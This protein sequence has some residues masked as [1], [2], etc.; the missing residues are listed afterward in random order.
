MVKC[1]FALFVLLQIVSP[2]L[3]VDVYIHLL[4]HPRLLC[5][6]VCPVVVGW[7]VRPRPYSNDSHMLVMTCFPVVKAAGTRTPVKTA[8]RNTWP[9]RSPCILTRAELCILPRRAGSMEEGLQEQYE[10]H[11]PTPEAGVTRTNKYFCNVSV[12][13]WRAYTCLM[14]KWKVFICLA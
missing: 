5:G 7:G 9:G 6:V 2:Y 3:V 10:M 8:T 13:T 11:L 14:H 12:C 4:S 1:R